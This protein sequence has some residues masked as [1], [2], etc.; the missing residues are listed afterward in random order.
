MLQGLVQ[1]H[2]SVVT[3]VQIKGASVKQEPEA[4]RLPL[5]RMRSTLCT[6]RL[7]CTFHTPLFIYRSCRSGAWGL[8]RG[9]T[10]RKWETPASNC[11][12]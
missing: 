6:R 7:T 5:T 11:K 9:L 2:V 1:G 10:A 8:A 3:A 12:C 4:R